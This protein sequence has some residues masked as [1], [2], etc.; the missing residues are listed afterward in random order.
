MMIDGRERFKAWPFFTISAAMALVQ[1][2]SLSHLDVAP[3]LVSL[4]P[5]LRLTLVCS[6]H[7]GA[8]EPMKQ[9]SD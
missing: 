2:T 8:V 1:A 9:Q 3:S 4:L 7:S 5:P 6:Q